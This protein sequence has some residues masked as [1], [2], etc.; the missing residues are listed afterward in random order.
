VGFDKGTGWGNRQLEWDTDRAE[1]V[2]LD[3]DG[4]LAIT[5]RQEEYEG[6]P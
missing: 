4:H 5:A 1:N 6:Q 3:G 2:S